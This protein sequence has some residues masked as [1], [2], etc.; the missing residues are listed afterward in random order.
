M[1]ES[2]KATGERGAVPSLRMCPFGRRDIAYSAG[3]D[4]L[5][6]VDPEYAAEMA[7][8]SPCIGI[9]CMAWRDG[10]CALIER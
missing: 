7:A 3:I 8:A 1:N 2:T 5:E 6:H 9:Y 10:G 4:G